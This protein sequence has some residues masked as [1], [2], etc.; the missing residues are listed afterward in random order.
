M[1]TAIVYDRVNKWGGAERVLLAL[2]EIFP[3]APLFTSVYSPDKAKW[4]QKFSKV[5]VSKLNKIPLF[6]DKHELLGTLMPAVFESF[7]FDGYDLVI[8]VTSEAA[9]GILTR[10]KTKHICYCLTPTR[11]LWSHYDTYFRG[12]LLRTVSKPVVSYLRRWDEIAAQRPDA[13]I[14]ISTEVQRRI[15]KYYS[16]ESVVVHPPLTLDVKTQ[17]AKF[18]TTTQNAKFF[19]IVS[20]LVSYKKVDLAIEAFNEINKSLYIIGIGSEGK[21]LMKIAKPNIKFLGQL[22]DEILAGYYKKAEAL[23]LPQEEDFGLVAVESIVAGTPVIAYC[24]GGALDII[25]EGVNGTFFDKQTKDDLVDAIKRFENLQFNV[26]IVKQSAKKFSQKRF[27]S[28]F[29]K[30]VKNLK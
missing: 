11:Y 12:R 18:K 6:R 15:K 9:K 8:S 2:H 27:K 21:R 1:R 7:N 13:M 10:G 26:K 23:I 3:D 20:R 28:E 14:A 25:K 29:L 19:L 24:A 4:V 5:I 17:N 22:T 16:R 30:V